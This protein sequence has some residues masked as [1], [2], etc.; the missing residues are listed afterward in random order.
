MEPKKIANLVSNNSR[1]HSLQASR[2]WT[3]K[4]D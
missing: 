2:A 4:D 1:G 3:D